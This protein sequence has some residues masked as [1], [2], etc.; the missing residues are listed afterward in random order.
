[1]AEF[2]MIDSEL[3]RNAD[4]SESANPEQPIDMYEPEP[5][6]KFTP[7]FESGPM[8]GGR[9]YPLRERRAPTTYA[10]LYILLTDESELECYD[11]AIAD[12]G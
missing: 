4:E 11:E 12:N 5:N 1:M 3:P 9:R 10:S 2:E 7:I 6:E 8:T